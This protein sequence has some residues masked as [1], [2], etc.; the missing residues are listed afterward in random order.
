LKF[1]FEHINE[2]KLQ[3]DERFIHPFV[4]GKTHN[5]INVENKNIPRI[6]I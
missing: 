5:R 4:T 1:L 2:N 3:E 6:V